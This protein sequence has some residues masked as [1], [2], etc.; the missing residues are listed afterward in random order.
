MM[1]ALLWNWRDSAEFL[2]LAPTIEIANNSFYP[3][4][5]MVRRDDDLATC[6]TSRTT[7]ARSRIG[8]PARR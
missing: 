4:R 6:F 3:A 2:I 5:D 7:T 8:P 1:T